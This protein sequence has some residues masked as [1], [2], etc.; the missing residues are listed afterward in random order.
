MSPP[1]VVDGESAARGLLVLR[2]HIG[3]SLPHG[4]DRLIET[5]PVVA[6]AVHRHPSRASRHHGGAS[7]HHGGALNVT[8][9]RIHFDIVE[10]FEV[11]PPLGDTARRFA[12]AQSHLSDRDGV[13]Y[14]LDTRPNRFAIGAISSGLAANQP[15]TT[16]TMATMN[17]I[18][19]AQPTTFVPANI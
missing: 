11:D 2:L 13:A 17:Q 19:P 8:Q 15:A 3:S 1:W 5:H 10:D 16:T 4:L 18:R 14:L 6:I 12:T 9:G 7:R